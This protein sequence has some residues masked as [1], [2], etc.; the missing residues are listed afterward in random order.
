MS[1]K[2]ENKNKANEPA[3]EYNSPQ[4]INKLYNAVTI[5]SFEEMRNDNYRH[6]LSL[7]PEQRLAEHYKLLIQVYNYKDEIEKNKQPLYDA[8]IFRDTSDFKA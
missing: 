1:E 2:D 4:E 6:W 7:T 8:I 3:A 5:S